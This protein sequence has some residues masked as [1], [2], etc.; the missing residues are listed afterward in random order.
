MLDKSGFPRFTPGHLY[1]NTLGETYLAA[2]VNREVLVSLKSGSV[3][4]DNPHS[5]FGESVNIAWKDIHHES[6]TPA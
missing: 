2:Y 4:S 6:T 5:P 1:Q 3:W